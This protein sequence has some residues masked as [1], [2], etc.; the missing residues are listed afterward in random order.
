VTGVTNPVAG[1]SGRPIVAPDPGGGTGP[2][3]S[4]VV[5]VRDGAPEPGSLVRCLESIAA[6][7]AGAGPVEVV[8]VDV[9]GDPDR[10]DAALATYGAA[11]PDL[12][13]RRFTLDPSY[14]GEAREVG[15]AA[16]RGANRLLVDPSVPVAPG[17]VAVLLGAGQVPPADDL[18]AR[19]DLVRGL[20]A[21]V[22][23]DAGTTARRDRALSGQLAWLRALIDDDP[24]KH[25]EVVAEARARRVHDLPWGEINRGRARDLAILFCFVPFIDTSGL[26]AARRLRE[27]G[28]VTDVVSQDMSGIRRS[29][30]ASLR[31]PAEVLDELRIL[32]GKR[33]VVKWQAVRRFTHSALA[34]VADLESAKGPYRSVYSRAMIQHSHFAAAILK[35][36]R[37]EI[38]WI[39]EFSDPLAYNAYGQ[40]R[41]GDVEDDWLLEELTEGFGAHGFPV[42][43]TRLSFTW[44][45]LIAYAFADEIIFT[46]AHQRDLMLGYCEERGLADRAAAI[47]RV[48]H[49]PV[50]GPEL[51][52]VAAPAYRLDPARV[53]IGFFGN[54]YPNRGLAEVLDALGRLDPAERDRIE[55]HVFTS[56]PEDL[57]EL[58]D[59]RG[60][61]AVM[62]V[63]PMLGYLEY[64]N[65]STRFDVLLINDYA[66]DPHFVPNPYLPAKLADYRG[67]GARI[68]SLYEPGSVLSGTEVDFASELG[69]T[70]A[71]TAV[72]RGLATSSAP[73]PARR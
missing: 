39:A 69:D 29:D 43:A 50:P 36:R 8:V 66:T 7:D 4:L 27:A 71:A 12:R 35:L 30:P 21:L 14:V 44:A 9:S 32:P 40:R 42:P 64:L 58:V 26:V 10:L 72:L 11:H 47:S 38:R 17:L 60:L 51:Y 15:L 65:L 2:Q 13:V 20:V 24:A 59:E 6:Q 49:H 25:A 68:W 5:V 37:P 46:N 41:V 34:E 22:A 52:D 73:R 33:H 45:E 70:D 18:G 53:H 62:R 28:V 56:K 61:G 57:Q 19:L 1:R 54:F 16:A 48:L 55:L 23:G 3:L 31:I 67:S 63:N